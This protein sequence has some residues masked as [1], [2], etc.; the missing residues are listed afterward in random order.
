MAQPLRQI[1]RKEN[2]AC[3]GNSTIRVPEAL[4]KVLSPV[5][6]KFQQRHEKRHGNLLNLLCAMEL[7]LRGAP[8]ISAI[9]AANFG[10][11][12]P[13]QSRSSPEIS[14][15]DITRARW[16]LLTGCSIVL[17]A[18]WLMAPA[19]SLS[20]VATTRLDPISARWAKRKRELNLFK[21][22]SVSA[23]AFS[24]SLFV[25][26]LEFNRQQ[27]SGSRIRAVSWYWR[28]LLMIILARQLRRQATRAGCGY[29]VDVRHG[30]FKGVT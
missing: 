5:L 8:I 15:H 2:L 19:R 27:R 25:P 4:A 7:C 3:S 17:R 30:L 24:M 18:C 1:I 13:T 28:C 9:Q 21:A 29:A 12:I 22:R 26:L 23:G 10:G 11:L 6:V 14:C 16:R 20:P